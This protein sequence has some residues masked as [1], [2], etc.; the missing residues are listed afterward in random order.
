MV[1]IQFWSD[2]LARR[3]RG[4]ALEF[5]LRAVRSSLND[6]GG[7]E[8]RVR[9]RLRATLEWCSGASLSDEDQIFLDSSP[10]ELTNVW[11][12]LRH[13]QRING[14]KTAVA[15][16]KKHEATVASVADE[17]QL[18]RIFSR[19]II[20]SI[21]ALI[22]RTRTFALTNTSAR[23]NIHKK[24]WERPVN[25]LQA[26]ERI[27]LQNVQNLQARLKQSFNQLGAAG[28]HLRFITL[29]LPSAF[30][31]GNRSFVLAG[32]PSRQTG[33]RLLVDLLS[34]A[35]GELSDQ[36]CCAG[37]W[38]IEP[39]DSGTPHLHALIALRTRSDANAFRRALIRQSVEMTFP[40]RSLKV[41]S[42][43]GIECTWNRTAAINIKSFATKDLD[44]IVP[45]VTKTLLSPHSSGQLP[46]RRYGLFG[47][48]WGK[49]GLNRIKNIVSLKDSIPKEL[50]RHTD[51]ASQ[52]S[53]A[54]VS[55]INNAELRI[56]KIDQTQSKVCTNSTTRGRNDW[57]QRVNRILQNFICKKLYQEP[58]IAN[59]IG[60]KFMQQAELSCT[61]CYA[62][63]AR[64]PP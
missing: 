28:W 5:G 35:R 43:I 30:H 60:R 24:I 63:S 4:S 49:D 23:L 51:G 40:W 26:A 25:L 58:L 57:Q 33:K 46:G 9:Q 31:P 11:N 32:S 61:D 16:Y 52:N 22:Q 34:A 21:Q 13:R 42:G 20:A 3:L 7:G 29:T 53:Q 12:R 64:A 37:Y 55:N 47:A 39:H 19:K 8:K 18:P 48:L 6:L 2:L 54:S 14:E 36:N 17:L 56:I 59:R 1:D 10:Q 45:Y 62:T 44:K 15:F 27:K 50:D 38:V 41:F